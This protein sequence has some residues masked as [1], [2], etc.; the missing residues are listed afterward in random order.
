M[1]NLRVRGTRLGCAGAL[2][3]AGRSVTFT[4]SRG[5]ACNVYEVPLRLDKPDDEA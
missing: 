1:S 4:S 5:N 3:P 2:A